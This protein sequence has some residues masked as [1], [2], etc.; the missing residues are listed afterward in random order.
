MPLGDAA[1]AGIGAGAV[2]DHGFARHDGGPKQGVHVGKFHA[3]FIVVF[4][5]FLGDLIPGNVGNAVGFEIGNPANFHEA[6]FHGG[7]SILPEQYLTNE[8]ILAI[9]KV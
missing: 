1:S 4:V 3:L 2:G 9:G 5:E 6:F 8:A 7:G